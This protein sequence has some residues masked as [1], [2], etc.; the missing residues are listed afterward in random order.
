MTRKFLRSSRKRVLINGLH[1]KTGGGVTYLRSMLP[2]LADDSE[3]ELHLFLHIDQ[4]QLFEPIDE[5]IRLHVLNFQSGFYRLLIWEQ[6]ALPI[7]AQVM[8]ADITFSPANY[9]PLFAPAQII[10]LRNS[11][12]V[13]GKETRLAKRFYWLA[14]ACMTAASLLLC[15]RAIAVSDYARKVLTF[16]L[17]KFVQD[18]VSIVMHGVDPIFCPDDNPRENFLLAVADI[19]V[20]KNLHNLI[21]AM[22]TVRDH[23]PDVT[24]KIAGH[25]TDSEYFSD[26]Q[27]IVEGKSL[28]AHIE[29]LGSHKAVELVELYRRCRLF[30]FPSTV[31]TF[32][33]PLVESM[34][35]GCAIVSSNTAAMPEILGPAG[36]YFDPM[37]ADDMAQKILHMLKEPSLCQTY[38]QLARDRAR[39]FS[40]KNTA[41]MTAEVLKS[42][43]LHRATGG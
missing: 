26:L 34:A 25:P 31:E 15:K 24:L 35:C 40:W 1:A 5:R 9:G 20:Q 2:L 21:N 41:R 6:I 7:L 8:S 11:L 36:L 18:R 33:N 43:V 29:F 22:A 14:L 27:K 13:V 3:I 37:D 39:L 10:L 32:G 12:A 42:V 19:Y 23:F 4:I 30:I 28:S 17:G 38:S 16:G